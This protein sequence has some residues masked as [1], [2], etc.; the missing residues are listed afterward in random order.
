MA[1]EELQTPLYIITLIFSGITA[2]LG[3]YFIHLLFEKKY[4]SLFSGTV[5]FIFTALTIG[6]V[7]FA[8]AELSWYLI[9]N[10]FNQLPSVSMPDFYWVVGDVF[11]LL[12]FITFSFY[13]HR[14]HGNWSK[15]SFLIIFSLVVIF[16]VIFYLS[17]VDLTSVEKNSGV[18]FLSYYYPLVSSLI[19]ISSTNV[20]LFFDKI[21][22]FKTSLLFFMIA[23]IGF[24]IADLLYIY[25]SA[26]NIYGLPGI[27]SDVLYIITYLLCSGSFLFLI[28]DV[29][30]EVNSKG[31][32]E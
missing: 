20:Y 22:K 16:G 2:V 31:L 3:I 19:L 4:R 25:Y 21:D 11:L 27:L 17:M 24:L 9:F 30:E 6:Y 15:S 26:N 8:L 23:N 7:F 13:M 32:I 5:R 29:K 1:G 14:E 28:L 12:G 18:V 10:V